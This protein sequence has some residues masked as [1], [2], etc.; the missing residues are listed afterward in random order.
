MKLRIGVLRSFSQEINNN[1]SIK[2]K[3]L[4]YLITL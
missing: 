2:L 1:V 3:S 4:N